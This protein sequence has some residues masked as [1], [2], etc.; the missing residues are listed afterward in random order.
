MSDKEDDLIITITKIEPV[1]KPMKP[2]YV[3]ILPNRFVGFAKK[4]CP[5]CRGSGSDPK[6]R[7][8]DP[9]TARKCPNL[10]CREGQVPAEI[11]CACQCH[12]GPAFCGVM[13]CCEYAGVTRDELEEEE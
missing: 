6:K 5:T 1:S 9:T 13:Q 11:P 7:R 8:L 4:Q 3:K 12:E 2:G 10:A